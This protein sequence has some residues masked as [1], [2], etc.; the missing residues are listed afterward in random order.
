MGV[1]L[2]D[3][4]DNSGNFDQPVRASR[5]RVHT[6]SFLPLCTIVKES[7]WVG[8]S[9]KKTTEAIPT[10]LVWSA[11]IDTCQNGQTL[12]NAWKI[13]IRGKAARS[14]EDAALT[15]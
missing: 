2:I 13:G 9:V 1:H 12:N 7:H 10:I 5:V 15:T 14:P 11:R 6:D 3:R 8:S 4:I